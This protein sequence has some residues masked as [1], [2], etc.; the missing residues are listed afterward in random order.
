MF[1]PCS[2]SFQTLGASGVDPRT[3]ETPPN[4]ETLTH[5]IFWALVSFRNIPAAAESL[6]KD[7]ADCLDALRVTWKP[8]RRLRRSSFVKVL[9]IFCLTPEHGASARRAETYWV[10][11]SLDSLAR[12][13]KAEFGDQETD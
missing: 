8:S 7:W 13:D 3:T 2:S 10:V 4:R 11:N 6:A 5:P 9:W 12:N 1:V